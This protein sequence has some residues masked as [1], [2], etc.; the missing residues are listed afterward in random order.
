MVTIVTN[1][2][3]VAV[4]HYVSALIAGLAY[5]IRMDISKINFWSR[6]AGI[7]VAGLV[8]VPT[9]PIVISWLYARNGECERLAATCLF[10][11]VLLTVSTVV[12][13]LYVGALG[14]IVTGPHIAPLMVFQA[15]AY[16]VAAKVLLFRDE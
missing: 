7:V 2:R 13:G 6:G 16:I 3:I 10:A 9:L 8:V 11:L 14:V 4:A 15:S 5:L 1:K 12:G